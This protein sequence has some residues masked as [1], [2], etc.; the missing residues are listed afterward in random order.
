VC[1]LFDRSSKL[2]ALSLAHLIAF[3]TRP[4]SL[5]IGRF[6]SKEPP[7]LRFLFNE[8]GLTFSVFEED[9]IPHDFHL[10]GSMGYQKPEYLSFFKRIAVAEGRNG[11][12]FETAECQ[13]ILSD[14]PALG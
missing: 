10:I 5:K 6:L 2:A 12:V 14:E 7:I 4:I 11:E 3:P 8:I 1:L 9:E 13:P